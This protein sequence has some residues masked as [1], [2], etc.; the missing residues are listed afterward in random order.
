VCILVII[1]ELRTFIIVTV[2]LVVSV[3]SGGF[4]SLS[5]ISRC[6]LSCICLFI[7]VN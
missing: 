4:I 3:I 5:Q 1:K 2:K 7:G 6:R